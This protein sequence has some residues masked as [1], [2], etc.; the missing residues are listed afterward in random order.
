MPI[1]IINSSWV[2]VPIESMM[3][4]GSFKSFPDILKT[5]EKNKDTAYVNG[6]NRKVFADAQNIKRPEDINVSLQALS[7]LL[8]FLKQNEKISG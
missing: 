7:G 4:E 3:S 6:V 2:G 5:I 8:H 1:G